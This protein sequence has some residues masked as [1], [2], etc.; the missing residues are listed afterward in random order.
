MYEM[1][2]VLIMIVWIVGVATGIVSAIFLFDLEDKYVSQP[3]KYF[4]T[5]IKIRGIRFF[6]RSA[7][8]TKF[9]L[10]T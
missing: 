6:S 2:A 9:W 4:I 3:V 5:D 7:A 8:S 1:M 10:R